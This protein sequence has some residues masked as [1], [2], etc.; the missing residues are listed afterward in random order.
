MQRPVL[1]FQRHQDDHWRMHFLLLLIP[2][3]H[4]DQRPTKNMCRNI[5]AEDKTPGFP[6]TMETTI[7]EGVGNMLTFGM[8]KGVGTSRGY[9]TFPTSSPAVM[10]YARIA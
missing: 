9:L 2:T 5:R 4:S 1:V 8:R 10:S 7:Y 3:P 6:I